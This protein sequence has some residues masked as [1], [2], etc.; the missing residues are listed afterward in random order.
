MLIY[1]MCVKTYATWGNE[2]VGRVRLMLDLALWPYV[3]AISFTGDQQADTARLLELN[4]KGHTAVHC[5]AVAE[6]G[7]RM[8]VRFGLDENKIVTAGLLHDISGII[9][10]ADMLTYAMTEGWSLDPAEE[11]HPFLLHQ[12]LSAVFA[13]RLLGVNDAAILS[14]V[15]C[16]TTLKSH[17][18]DLDMA[19]FLADKLAWDQC[20]TPP[21]YGSAMAALDDSLAKA[22]LV[23]IDYVLSHGMILLAHR[24]LSQAKAWLEISV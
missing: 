18:S 21:F 4:G 20:S 14:A 9:K 22:S 7:R 6:Q 15:G 1:K 19:L 11:K 5:A 10:P 8:A 17:A 13:E 16:H 24:W 2:Q 3:K 12:R 23:Y